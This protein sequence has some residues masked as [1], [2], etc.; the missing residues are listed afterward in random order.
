MQAS[1][2]TSGLPF[3]ASAPVKQVGIGRLGIVSNGQD[4]SDFCKFLYFG[5]VMKT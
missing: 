5:V 2:Q 1:A 4:K 3:I